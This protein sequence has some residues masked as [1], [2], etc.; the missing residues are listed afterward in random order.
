MS[1][2]STHKNLVEVIYEYVKE[3]VNPNEQCLICADMAETVRPSKVIGNYIP[4]VL[5]WH[6][7]ILVIGEAKTRNDILRPHS[8]AQYKA[9]FDE[10]KGFYGKSCFVIGVPWDMVVTV[11][12]Y[13]KRMKLKE[14]SVADVVIINEWGKAVK[15]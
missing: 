14:N 1:E 3:N 9:Y 5:F 2:S 10:F 11:K 12:N 8:Q 4:D 6:D 15:I 7:D 13:F